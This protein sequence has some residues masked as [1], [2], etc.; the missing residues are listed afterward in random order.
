MVGHLTSG[1]R[2]RNYRKLRRYARMGSALS[3][4]QSSS[5][6]IRHCKQL[7]YIGKDIISFVI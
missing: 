1:L 2:A 5:E 4:T 6:G 7:K 3:E